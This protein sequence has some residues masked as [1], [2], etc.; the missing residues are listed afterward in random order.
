MGNFTDLVRKNKIKGPTHKSFDLQSWEA[1]KKTD[2]LDKKIYSAGI[3]F[4]NQFNKIRNDLDHISSHKIHLSRDNFLKSFISI[5]NLEFK[6]LHFLENTNTS[7]S[8][9]DVQTRKV[10]KSSFGSDITFDELAH[11]CVDGILLN[12]IYHFNDEIKNN[13]DISDSETIN[14]LS[15]E[16]KLSQLY[17]IYSYYWNGI[18]FNQLDFFVKNNNTFISENT[19]LNII[20]KCSHI[21]DIQINFNDSIHSYE[22]IEALINNKLFICYDL[23]EFNHKK[24]YDLPERLKISILT[25]Y[26]SYFSLKNDFLEKKS[27]NLNFSFLD[28]FN[29]FIQLSSLSYYIL[30]QIRY[31]NYFDYNKLCP[32]IDLF[33][34][35]NQLDFINNTD[36][37]NEIIKFISFDPKR[38]IKADLWRMPIIKLQNEKIILCL[39]SLLH[40]N[41][42]RCLEGWIQEANE[43]L[44]EKGQKF[45]ISFRNEIKEILK[46]SDLLFD[47][48]YLY[49]PNSKY[50]TFNQEKYEI[51]ILFR[52]G[53]H[54]FIGEAKCLVS[55][56]SPVSN[57]NIYES[58]K[59]GSSQAIE[60]QNFIIKNIENFSQLLNFKGETEKLK[61]IP[62]IVNSNRIFTGL[63]IDNVPVIDPI[64]FNQYFKNKNLTIL[65]I[66]DI[67]LASLELYKNKAELINNFKKYITYPPTI[68]TL[69]N[70]VKFLEPM[71][72]PIPTSN[73]EK[74]C[75]FIRL[76]FNPV[77]KVSDLSNISYKFSKKINTTY[78]IAL[79]RS[80][81]PFK[82][83]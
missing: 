69:K 51:D 3:Y 14:Y 18:L 42:S 15:S 45:E 2:S 73:Y 4:F 64:I 57:W 62:F 34:L 8:L 7:T 49:E 29:V 5:S 31:Q 27:I 77:N 68:Q 72:I 76:S 65:A 41:Y 17:D 71:L 56:D 40:P 74:Y 81:L 75:Y 61:V 9:I 11:A 30:E 36:F 39:A 38:K 50:I 54:I 23:E 60:R 20:Y 19:E 26:S 37:S 43:K 13:E 66:N 58:L 63:I 80:L 79:N 46:E 1:E 33:E 16:F 78:N 59:K 24:F 25:S 52:I 53:N 82:L 6:K 35:I 55:A 10:T 12:C 83:N 22:E 28:I 47:D 44:D 48:Y 70:R 21:R 32:E 67:T